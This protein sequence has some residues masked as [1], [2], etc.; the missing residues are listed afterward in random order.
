MAPRQE[1]LLRNE[2]NSSAGREHSRTET[3]AGGLPTRLGL[4]LTPPLS[5]TGQRRETEEADTKQ[6]EHGGLGNGERVVPGREL[7]WTR[8]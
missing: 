8:V 3:L 1:A 5:A 6:P 4:H 2:P 7:T